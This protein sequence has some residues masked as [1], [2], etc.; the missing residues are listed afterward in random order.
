M[1]ENEV[2]RYDNAF[3]ECGHLIISKYFHELFEVDYVTLDIDLAKELDAQSLGGLKFNA[4]VLFDSMSV[5][6]HDKVIL[7]SLA[8][9]CADDIYFYCGEVNQGEFLPRV[10]DNKFQNSRYS[11]DIPIFYKHFE[12]IKDSVYDTHIIFITITLRQ[13]CELMAGIKVWPILTSMRTAL[14]E[15]KDK[16]LTDD[17]INEI[18]EGAMFSEFINSTKANFINDRADL[19]KGNY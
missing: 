1:E 9:L 2:Q 8:G 5:S 4:K 6:D 17:R 7:M 11:G 13:I 16:T 3:H 19:Y 12:R 14:L 18:L 15:S 10:W